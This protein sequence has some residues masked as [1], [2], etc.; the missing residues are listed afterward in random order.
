MEVEKDIN[1][2]KY[3]VRDEPFGFTIYDHSNLTRR[4]FKKEELKPYL[5]ENNIKDYIYLPAK[6]KEYRKD[7]LYSPLRIYYETTLACNLHCKFCFNKSGEP[8]KNELT[9]EEVIASLYSLRGDNVILAQITGQPRPDPD[10]LELKFKDFEFGSLHR[11]SFVRPSILFTIHKS[12]IEYKIGKLKE[13]KIKEIQN[14]LIELF[15]K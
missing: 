6:H 7:I 14:K 4:F 12:R 11:A 8:R 15:S 13:E 3:T 9:T 1:S 10:L 5:E 2:K